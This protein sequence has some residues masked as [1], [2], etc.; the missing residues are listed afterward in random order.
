MSNLSSRSNVVCLVAVVAMVAS[1]L[2]GCGGSRSDGPAMHEVSGAVSFDGTPVEDGRILLR[3]KE[4]DGK[5]FSGVIKDGAY[6]VETEEGLMT[7]EIRASRIIPGKFDNSNGTPEPVG[8]MYIPK[9]YNTETTLEVL[10]PEGGK[11]DADF[12]L[13]S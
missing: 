9:Q 4:G 12:T 11:S 7:V 2:V 6:T 13:E 8:E 10:V 5:A 1:S 3:K